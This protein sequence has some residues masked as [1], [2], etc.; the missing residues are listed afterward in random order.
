[1]PEVLWSSA[2]LRLL[3]GEIDAIFRGQ[4]DVQAINAQALRHGLRE[5]AL[6]GRWKGNL[7]GVEETLAD[8][9]E[10]GTAASALDF[11]IACDI[12]QAAKARQLFYPAVD[13]LIAR[14]GRDHT[15]ASE[16]QEFREALN[17]AQA[18]AC[19]RL[20]QSQP[21]L[22][23][24]QTAHLCVALAS[25]PLDQRPKP[26]STGIPSLD[27]DMRGGVIPGKGEGTW[28]LVAR[29]G[30]GKTTVAI[31]AAMGLACNGA[32][33]LVLSCELTAWPR[34]CIPPATWRAGA[35]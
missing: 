32:S 19:G 35:A 5:R 8:L 29:S 12:F 11:P 21:V 13:R 4:R 7:Q 31:A 3:A 9:L 33:L 20:R 25:M 14:R 1:V 6:A 28:V 2:E 24:R 17:E 16:L 18:I 22:S 27:L 15:I 10:W 23:A 30:I 34:R 26:I